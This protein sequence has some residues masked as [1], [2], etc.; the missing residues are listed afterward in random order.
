MIGGSEDLW[1]ASS[2]NIYDQ[3][4]IDYKTWYGVPYFLRGKV[5]MMMRLTRTK[6]RRTKMLP[7]I[8]HPMKTRV[9]PRYSAGGEL[10][11]R[12]SSRIIEKE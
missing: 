5:K 6:T 8:D 2:S 11:S 1:A 10:F 9:L 12:C 7:S 3:L 4:V